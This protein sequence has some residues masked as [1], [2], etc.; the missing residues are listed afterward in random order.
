MLHH[1]VAPVEICKNITLQGCR[2]E[3]TEAPADVVSDQIP[4]L[5][6]TRP[7][8]MDFSALDRNEKKSLLF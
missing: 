5:R 3:E 2:E 6:A 7:I 1:H 8:I 4:I